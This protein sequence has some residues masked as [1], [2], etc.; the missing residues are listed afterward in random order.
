MNELA[1]RAVE[2][3][4]TR[5]HTEAPHISVLS[6]DFIVFEESMRIVRE[7][8][9]KRGRGSLVSSIEDSEEEELQPEVLEEMLDP[10]RIRGSS[11]FGVRA[12]FR[13]FKEESLVKFYAS[14]Y[15]RTSPPSDFRKVEVTAVLKGDGVLRAG[16][17]VLN[18][19]GDVAIAEEH[20][21]ARADPH[22][23]VGFGNP[24]F[25]QVAGNI[26]STVLYRK[27]ANVA[28][29][30]DES[31]E[32]ALSTA[33][34]CSDGSIF[35]FTSP[36]IS[37]N[38]KPR[39]DRY[40]A[41]QCFLLEA[42]LKKHENGSA[43][44]G[45]VL[46]Y[47]GPVLIERL[48]SKIYDEA[49]PPGKNIPMYV[50]RAEEGC[51]ER[52]VDRWSIHHLFEVE[53][54]MM[55][56]DADPNWRWKIE[57][58]REYSGLHGLVP[59]GCLAIMEDSDEILERKALGGFS[60]G[61]LLR[62]WHVVPEEIYPVESSQNNLEE[63]FASAVEYVLRNAS[64]IVDG[65]LLK[66]ATETVLNGLKNAEKNLRRLYRYQEESLREG[67]LLLVSR[68]SPEASDSCRALVLQARTAGGKTLAFL[69]PLLV[70]L[71]YLKLSGRSANMQSF[72]T[73]A[74]L[75]YPTTALQN[76]QAARIFRVLWEINKILNE[77]GSD[78]ISIGILHGHTPWREDMKN[79]HEMR[80]QCPL[81]G[82]RLIVEP[83]GGLPEK[84]EKVVCSNSKCSL[85]TISE[86]FNLLNRSVR[87]TRDSIYTNP[88]DILITNPDIINYRLTLGGKEDPQSLVI[89]GKRVYRCKNCGE[90][91]DTIKSPKKC[92]K[93]GH[94]S[95]QL[96]DPSFPQI[97][98]IDEAHLL[99]GAFG[100]QVSHLLTRIEEFMRMVKNLPESYRPLY[101][102][103]SATLN[104]PKKRASELTATEESRIKIISARDDVSSSPEKYIR[105]MH[106]FIMP[107]TYAPQSTVFRIIEALY[108]EASALEENKKEEFNRKLQDAKKR[109]FDSRQPATLTFVNRISEAN[110]LLSFIR[111]LPGVRADGHTT[112][113]ARD[114]A[115]VEDEFS[116]GNLDIIV[117]TSGLE[118][119][120]DF[121]RVD[122][123]IIYGMPFYI[124]DYT[125]RIG[126]VGRK[127]HC[128]IFNIF[129]PDKPVDHFY[130]RNWR[131]LSDVML[132]GIH[133]R[134]EAYRIER[135]NPEALRKTGR[136]A[137]L[138]I[139]SAERG[140]DSIIRMN[141]SQHGNR[142]QQFLRDV[143]S[144][145]QQSLPRAVG[146]AY[147]ATSSNAVQIAEN[148]ALEFLR[149]M[150]RLLGTYADLRR[151]L[152]IG[153]G[154]DLQ[155]LRSLRSL[156]HQTEYIFTNIPDRERKRR[157]RDIVYSFRHCLSGQI[158]SYRGLYFS[159][160]N[161]EVDSLGKY[162]RN[163]L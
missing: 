101:F 25:V 114:K 51:G 103:S 46:R 72:G 120:V 117:A 63:S 49:H 75:F 17:R 138:D 157:S 61:I 15:I 152:R 106:V 13:N 19:A 142:L 90:I 55:W 44:V 12:S 42:S 102:I 83:H 30:E 58:G 80:M 60:G 132:R 149:R 160:E 99:R 159:V 6:P 95:F 108:S 43:T 158:I 155:Q 57:Q 84:P 67:L 69:L 121:D 34:R 136:R 100:A 11:T 77:K 78:L 21:E 113:Y 2:Y 36:K 91:Y 7:R 133:M 59:I 53:G 122:I 76:D 116:R 148:E 105:R 129:M 111:S 37:R 81:C 145:L 32:E 33:E 161:C 131:L 54:L 8:S 139:I 3:L 96:T 68:A 88:P 124:S 146:C 127:S 109:A 23:V 39:S 151:V 64:S 87:A 107:R 154:R 24:A 70:Y 144:H 93:C 143:E 40:R 79:P 85:N 18:E 66:E 128:I 14:F 123:G 89:L 45:F 134:S 137:V 98:V 147:G 119:G 10:T 74:L 115:R 150:Q 1:L 125:Q 135:E 38:E 92:R 130:Y 47:I 22:A 97:I 126:R 35:C 141:A 140:A 16:V 82:S 112:D 73:K 4:R 104:N 50:V 65:E 27:G 26:I 118:V 110:E 41:V 162:P 28:V 71:T 56:R 163:I 31:V 9:G 86:L 29:A 156:E 48:S 5:Y 52:T 20:V 62:D 153:L 94:R